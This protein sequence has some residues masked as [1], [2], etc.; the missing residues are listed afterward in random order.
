MKRKK[1]LITKCLRQHLAN[2]FHKQYILNYHS[3]I[4]NKKYLVELII[5]ATVI[6]NLMQFFR[7]ECGR[8]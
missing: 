4:A 5:L 7:T 8:L 6:H 1:K 3:F 2:N